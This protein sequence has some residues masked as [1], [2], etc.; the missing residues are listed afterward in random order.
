M[1]ETLYGYLLKNESTIKKN[2]PVIPVS[3]DTN[4]LVPLKPNIWKKGNWAFYENDFK[5][6]NLTILSENNIKNLK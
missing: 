3:N 6:E 2:H 1:N 4:N 5:L